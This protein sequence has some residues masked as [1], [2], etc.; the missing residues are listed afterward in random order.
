MKRKPIR[1]VNRPRGHIVGAKWLELPTS[2]LRARVVRVVVADTPQEKYWAR[3]LVGQERWAV[4]MN[5]VTPEGF[6]T[7]Y[8]DNEDGKTVDKLT[9]GQGDPALGHRQLMVQRVIEH[10]PDVKVS[11]GFLS[12][13]ARP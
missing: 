13:A 11:Y 7:F 1:A 2:I 3:E 9:I 10:H 4:E 5:I 8:L 12:K 6:D